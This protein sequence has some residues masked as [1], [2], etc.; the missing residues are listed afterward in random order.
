MDWRINGGG[1]GAECGA[2]M[3]RG[4]INAQYISVGRNGE[5]SGDSTHVTGYHRGPQR[6]LVT[7]GSQFVDGWGRW[8]GSQYSTGCWFGSGWNQWR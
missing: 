3:G 5:V 2:C 8:E 7:A 4:H 6:L 1:N